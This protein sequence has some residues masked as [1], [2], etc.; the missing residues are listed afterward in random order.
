MGDQ[1]EWYWLSFADGNLPVGKQLLGVA[2]VG[3]CSN[4]AH[5]AMVAHA[6]GCN[7]GGEVMGHIV[8]G[9]YAEAIPD[10]YRF[11]LLS[12]KEARHV[13]VVFEGVN[14]RREGRAG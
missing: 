11:T 1:G 3:P 4:I 2:L 14:R 9:P 10:E 5:A 13:D 6:R 12:K 7:P 8:P